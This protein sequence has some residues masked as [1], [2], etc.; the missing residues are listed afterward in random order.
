MH[1]RPERVANLLGAAALAVADAQSDAL[2]RAETALGR[3]AASALVTIAARPGIGA[4]RLRKALA[5]SQPGVARLVDGLAR[6]GWVERRPGADARSRA[7]YV[8]DEGRRVIDRLLAARRAAVQELL[9]PLGERDRDT[10]ARL[11][12]KLLGAWTSSP[13]DVER[14]CRLC[15][16]RVC[17]RC[18][19]AAAPKDLL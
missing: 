4:E 8:T 11:L 12:E 17:E 15:E 1:S 7:L 19:V 14:L 18:P 5:L 9:V 13:L 2:E 10:L 16:R 6:A 3:S